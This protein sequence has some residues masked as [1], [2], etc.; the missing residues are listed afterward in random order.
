MREKDRKSALSRGK[1]ATQSWRGGWRERDRQTDTGEKT[2]ES[3]R[4][5]MTERERE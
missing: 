4:E 5:M 3:Q 1:T 2:K